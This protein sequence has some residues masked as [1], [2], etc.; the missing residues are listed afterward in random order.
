MVRQVLGVP[1]GPLA[2]H[3]P[4]AFSFSTDAMMVL[5]TPIKLTGMWFAIHKHRG[6][7]STP[8]ALKHAALMYANAG[9]LCVLIMLL[10]CLIGGGSKSKVACEGHLAG[11]I[12][13]H[14]E[15]EI[16]R[17]THTFSRLQ[18]PCRCH[19]IVSC[20]RVV[21]REDVRGRAIPV[22][23]MNGNIAAPAATAA[24]ARQSMCVCCCRQLYCCRI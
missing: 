6:V 21:N 3:G 11:F 4:G 5:L 15:Q 22:I 23:V 12:Q 1:R 24:F 10:D 20:F 9:E 14:L 18:S 19:E 8:P 16:K 13:I 17:L 2:S 7:H